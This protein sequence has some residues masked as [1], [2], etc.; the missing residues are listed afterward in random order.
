MDKMMKDSGVEWIGEIPREWK[1][2]KLKYL[3]AKNLQYGANDSGIEYADDLPRYVRITDILSDGRLREDEKLSLEENVAYD[4]LLEDGDI[5]FARSGATV[6]KSFLYRKEYGRCAFAGYLIRAK[7]RNNISTRY[8]KHWIT[9]AGYEK[10]KDSIF[11]QS[12]IQNIGADKYANLIISLPS[13]YEQQEKIADYLDDKVVEIDKVISDTNATIEEY[14]KYKQAVIIKAVTKGLNDSVKMK[15]TDS[16]WIGEIPEHWGYVRIQRLFETIDERNEDDEA[17]LLS[18][19]TAIG[20]K[21]RSELEEKGNKASTVLNYKKVQKDDVIVNKL[22][23]WMGAIG[24]SD[25]EGVTSP[26]YDVYRKRKGANVTRSFYNNYFRYTCFKGDCYKYGHGIMLMRWRTYPEEFLRIKVPN[27][28]QEEQEQI[29]EY[30]DKK[31]VEIDSLIASKEALVAEL[32]AYKK[33][34]IYEYVT[35]KKEVV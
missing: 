8:I 34:V 1:T 4:Y 3:L 28:P 18:L 24:Y 5:L 9:S 29:A 7:I 17:T 26:D 27:P 22:L 31:V 33:S 32:E 10:W 6:G 30:L 16:E 25:Y 35:G 15:D 2:Y 21:P 23:A 13:S 19:Y 14:K 20:V 12:T 11:I